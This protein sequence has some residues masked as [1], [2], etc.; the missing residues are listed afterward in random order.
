MSDKDVV[1]SVQEIE[2][3]EAGRFR[4]RFDMTEDERAGLVDQLVDE[5]ISV[6]SV[7]IHSREDGDYL[8]YYLVADDYEQMLE[9]WR[10]SDEDWANDYR[11]FL[12]E[13][14]ADGHEAY[15]QERPERIFHID[16]DDVGD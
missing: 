10:E 5:G 9:E 4:E 12:D 6:E 13:T 14:L 16:V 3:G 2:P 15:H 7:F 11:E 1:L 8:L